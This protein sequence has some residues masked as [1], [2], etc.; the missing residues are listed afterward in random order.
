MATIRH[1]VT[2]FQSN[3]P[4]SMM[5]KRDFGHLVIVIFLQITS[6]FAQSMEL[7][8]VL[9]LSNY[10][11]DLI[12]KKSVEQLRHTHAA[13]SPF[14]RYNFND[15]FSLKAF[16]GYCAISGD[17]ALVSDPNQKKRNLSFNSNIFDIGAMA[18]INLFGFYGLNQESPLSPYIGFGI[19]GF[20]FDPTAQYQ[21]EKVRLQPLGTEGQGMPGFRSKYSLFNFAIPVGGGVKYALTDNWNVGLD[22]CFR[23]TFTDYLDDV[24]GSYVQYDQLLA[25]NGTLA[26]ALGNRI[27]EG[28]STGPDVTTKTGSQRGNPNLK[29]WYYTIGIFVSYNW[30]DSVKVKTRHRMRGKNHCPSW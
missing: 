23:K 9:G 30:Y 19:N 5:K 20:Y 3:R 11:G 17:D 13:I 29:D 15:Y 28:Q 26:A 12:P 27:G 24:S 21:G 10:N 22:I 2:H 16:V 7:G 14:L 4:Y 18:E 25:G 1:R 8:V 6:S